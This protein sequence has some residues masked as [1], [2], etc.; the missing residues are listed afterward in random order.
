MMNRVNAQLS[1]LA[2]VA[3]ASILPV[4]AATSAQAQA[5]AAAPAPAPTPEAQM[6]Q[7]MQQSALT[8]AQMAQMSP[9]DFVKYQQAQAQAFA[10][11]QTQMTP[12][13]AP[14]GT[15]ATQGPAVPSGELPPGQLVSGRIALPAQQATQVNIAMPQVPPL[16]AGM[17]AGAAGSLSATKPG[18][19]LSPEEFGALLDGKLPLSPEQ[20]REVN[21]RMDATRRAV[22]AKPG[23]TP[24][25]VSVS[26]RVTLDAGANPHVLRLS[27]DTVT[28]VVFTDVTGAPWNIQKVVTGAKSMLEVMHKED[29]ARSNMFTI[30]PKEEYVSTNIAVFLVGAPAPVMMAVETNQASVDYRV[31]VSVQARGPAAVMPAVSRGLSESVSAELVSMVA[32]VTPNLARP[33]KVVASEVPDVQ[34]WVLGD[35]MFLRTK[36]NVLTP[37]VPKDGK[38]ATGAD[39]TKVYELPL[40]PEVRLLS[41]GSVARL[42]LAGFPSPGAVATMATA[43]K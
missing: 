20:I 23:V 11:L 1:R 41:G 28:S 39:G 43:G 30:A 35:R 16:P 14:A 38:V 6:M 3:V 27:I 21:Q 42:Q 26:A 13:Q 32:G 34:A 12:P 15:P 5:R 29:E 40:A 36:A 7:V 22:R 17:A 9:A 8:P 33:L 19:G 4:L 37:A 2:R 10:A 24:R 18:E 31:D 25:P